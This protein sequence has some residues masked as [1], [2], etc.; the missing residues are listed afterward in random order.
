MQAKKTSKS[1]K[2]SRSFKNLSPETKLSAA[3]SKNHLKDWANRR[4]L[5]LPL[6]SNV[7]KE[8]GKE[9]TI[10]QAKVEIQK[11]HEQTQKSR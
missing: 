8:L 10:A 9:A 5:S 7:F 3:G 6:V 1:F 11:R 4:Q 2:T